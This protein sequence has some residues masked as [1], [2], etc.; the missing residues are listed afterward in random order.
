L[1]LLLGACS[2]GTK[3]DVHRDRIPTLFSAY[4]WML[5]WSV[6]TAFTFEKI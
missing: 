2:S 3:R 1:F 6:R 4:C 5:I